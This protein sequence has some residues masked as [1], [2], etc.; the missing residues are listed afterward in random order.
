MEHYRVEAMYVPSADAGGDLLD[1][2]RHGR[3]RARYHIIEQA[4]DQRFEHAIE[5]VRVWRR[6]PAALPTRGQILR[7]QSTAGASGAPSSAASRPRRRRTRT[8]G[9]R[10]PLLGRRGHTT[11]QQPL[12]RRIGEVA[13]AG[14]GG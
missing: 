4:A 3:R 2:H 1:Q 11:G 13:P 7:A 9:P 8:G 12:A 14:C 6:A 10:P 5:P